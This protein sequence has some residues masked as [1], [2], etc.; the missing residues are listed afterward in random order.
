M[1]SAGR[2][3]EKGRERVR[4]VREF[5][6]FLFRGGVGLEGGWA[7]SGLVEVAVV[8]GEVGTRVVV[9][10]IVVVLRFS[11]KNADEAKCK[12]TH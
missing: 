5:P 9:V 7:L 8:M 10:R 4:G 12:M 2:G 1:L 6:P 3:G 11:I